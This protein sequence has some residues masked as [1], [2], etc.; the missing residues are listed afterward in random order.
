MRAKN[1]LAWLAAVILS[2]VAATSRFGDSGHVAGA[3]GVDGGKV[4]HP[5]RLDPG[6]SQYVLIVT[7]AVQPPYRGRARV[8]LE[9]E[10][11]MDYEVLAS[12]PVVN[13][14]LYHRP[15]LVKGVLEDLRPGDRFALWITLRP[16]D[17]SATAAR[18][19]PKSRHVV[20]FYDDVT[21]KPL[22]RVPVIYGDEG[23]ACHAT[24][25]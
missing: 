6:K 21:G 9:G 19:N 14:G 8:V 3:L 22:M 10:P 4:R 24:E 11:K 12:T 18:P 25:G 15:T 20:A 17:P 1:V 5:L 16:P 2:S 13:L 23:E 7:G